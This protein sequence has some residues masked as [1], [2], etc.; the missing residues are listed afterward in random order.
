MP[1]TTLIDPQ[2]RS[3][4]LFEFTWTNHIV[5]R[6]PELD[7][8]R[9]LVEQTI[10]NP[11]IITISGYDQDCRLYHGPWFRPAIMIRVAADVARGIVKTAHLIR[12]VPAKEV[13]E[14]SRPKL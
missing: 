7:G 14:W 6:H 5:L 8:Y 12:R 9:E 4:V 10:T 13:V 1:D 2:G 3:L 11:A